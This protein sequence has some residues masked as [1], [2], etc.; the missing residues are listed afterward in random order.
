MLCVRDHFNLYIFYS[1]VILYTIN[2]TSGRHSFVIGVKNVFVTP[3]KYLTT[4]CWG[5]VGIGRSEVP[6]FKLHSFE[7]SQKRKQSGKTDPDER[8]NE[9]PSV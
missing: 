5:S 1:S 9:S 6:A 3:G 7:A 4:W 8:Q 2:E